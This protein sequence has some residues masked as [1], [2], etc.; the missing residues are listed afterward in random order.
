[1]VHLQTSAESALRLSAAMI[2]LATFAVFLR[3]FARTKIISAVGVEDAL[4]S[5]ALCFFLA[6][7]GLFLAGMLGLEI[8]VADTNSA[9]RSYRRS[10]FR[11]HI[12]LLRDDFAT[13]KQILQ[14]LMIPRD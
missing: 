10:R 3:L 2:V 5:L 9:T 12:R 1:M 14:G 4:I 11:R 13:I 8:A 6:Y 7:Q